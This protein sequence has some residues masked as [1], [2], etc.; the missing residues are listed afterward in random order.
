MARTLKRRSRP[1]LRKTVKGGNGYGK[2]DCNNN[3]DGTISTPQKILRRRLL[4]DMYHD[5]NN[6]NSLFTRILLGRYRLLF[7]GAYPVKGTVAYAEL[8]DDEELLALG[9]PTNF[10]EWSLFESILGS[11]KPIAGLPDPLVQPVTPAGEKILTN[12]D[13]RR[14]RAIRFTI[15]H[16]T[17]YM[18]DDS[19]V[20]LYA[21][22]PNSEVG[23]VH[24]ALHPVF[25]Q[26]GA[27]NLITFASILD[28][29]PKPWAPKDNPVF[30]PYPYPAGNPGVEY[31]LCEYGFGPFLSQL[32]ITGFTGVKVSCKFRGFLS[33]SENGTEFCPGSDSPPGTGPGPR[34]MR[35]IDAITMGIP[36]RNPLKPINKT[37]PSVSGFFTSNAETVRIEMS[38]AP[39]KNK[40]LYYAGKA[41]GDT[42]LVMS[43]TKNL[44]PGV[45][46]PMLISPLR[47]LYPIGGGQ[48]A[49]PLQRYIV[50]THDILEAV[51]AAVKD[52]AF[53]LENANVGPGDLGGYIF[54]PGNDD[55]VPAVPPGPAGAAAAA[56]IT[57]AR[58]LASDKLRLTE[59]LRDQRDKIR[60]S[61][62][63]II[64]AFNYAN[65]H[66][67]YES[68]A[69]PNQLPVHPKIIPLIIVGLTSLRDSY[70]DE[71]T[72]VLSLIETVPADPIP[73]NADVTTL[74]A[75]FKGILACKHQVL[76]RP[77]G[78][79]FNSRIVISKNPV[80]VFLL[81]P[82]LLAN[83]DTASGLFR[84]FLYNI[85][86]PQSINDYFESVNLDTNYNLALLRRVVSTFNLLFPVPAPAARAVPVYVQGIIAKFKKPGKFPKG[87]DA[88]LF[89]QR[90]PIIPYV[91]KQ[92]VFQAVEE[93]E[94]KERL[95]DLTPVSGK[96]DRLEKLSEKVIYYNRNAKR[97]DKIRI[98]QQDKELEKT[99]NSPERKK[100]IAPTA[101]KSATVLDKLDNQIASLGDKL[102]GYV[103]VNTRSKTLLAEN[104]RLKS[105]FNTEVSKDPADFINTD[106]LLT[107]KEKPGCFSLLSDCFAFVGR[108]IKETIFMIATAY[109]YNDTNPIA[110]PTTDS[111]IL[112]NIY[113]EAI[114]PEVGS[115]IQ[116]GGGAPA[117]QVDPNSPMPWELAMINA[118]CCD[119]NANQFANLGYINGINAPP[120]INY[121]SIIVKSF[122]KER[123]MY[124]AAIGMKMNAEGTSVE[125]LPAPAPATNEPPPATTIDLN[126]S[127]VEYGKPT[128]GVSNVS[129]DEN[130]GTQ[131]VLGGQR[132]S[133]ANL[134]I[135]LMKSGVRLGGSL[136]T[137]LT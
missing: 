24:D 35:E 10:S 131:A 67:I 63:L 40:I 130:P 2:G 87:L 92:S 74:S 83:P 122:Q 97:I 103:G 9:I 53:I 71:Y 60:N 62:K 14:R 20:R 48:L 93:V 108:S 44:G 78:C 54:I 72:R 89:V 116:S 37:D 132:V 45:T 58:L 120:V 136:N 121:D 80:I 6:G 28:Q 51:T 5:A 21:D 88:D 118:F 4:G 16:E 85:Y 61:Y 90:D 109:W 127:G 128:L 29:A 12:W 22:I 133:P 110:Y 59:M 117:T 18:S 46:N 41:L 124:L 91:A 114:S 73:P 38:V 30:Y 57:A 119:F 112:E 137:E 125:P 75:K 102:P 99:R 77:G 98:L 69:S 81:P 1:M 111:V 19:G 49:P 26:L 27:A 11:V 126:A 13:E 79:Y 50:K 64:E 17:A 105:H 52:E 84:N 100:K 106:N 15:D 104:E 65:Q 43:I 96:L 56:A 115:V 32:I 23:I 86:T 66:Y 47:Y 123:D 70:I 8:I 129:D 7:G 34:V 68:S 76:L 39:D 25:K 134:T 42:S 31:N 107:S 113:E 135:D 82:S 94:R 101:T 95:L 3:V 33:M 36:G 55:D